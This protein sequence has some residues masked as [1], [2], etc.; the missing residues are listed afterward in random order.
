LK[1]DDR[2]D[3]GYS[4]RFHACHAEK[5]LIAFFVHKHLFL[6]HEIGS[7][8]EMAELSIQDLPNGRL[9]ELIKKRELDRRLSNL[10]AA[11]PPVFLK[12]ATIL[13]SW[14]CCDDYREFI[15]RT[16]SKPG[17]RITVAESTLA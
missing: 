12:T 13:T 8:M 11:R 3:N 4:G 15:K 9:E 14:C 1:P 10:A 16:N 17:L 7:E 6:P 2:R 5:Q